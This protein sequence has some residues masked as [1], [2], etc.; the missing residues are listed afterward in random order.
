MT[1][2]PGPL[3]RSRRDTP[4]SPP[5]SA[6]S[7]R[8]W[9]GLGKTPSSGPS[10]ATL[11]Q[12]HLTAVHPFINQVN[13]DTSLSGATAAPGALGDSLLYAALLGTNVVL[14]ANLSWLNSAL[15]ANQVSWRSGVV[16]VASRPSPAS[17]R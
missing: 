13:E 17:T 9:C 12:R 4:S 3:T 16:R 1:V 14:D 11:A 6:S 7:C 8:S 10:Y 15:R 2:R 5:R